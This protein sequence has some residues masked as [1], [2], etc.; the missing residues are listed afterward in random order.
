MIYRL[1]VIMFTD[2]VADP[3][4]ALLYSK[5][6]L[7]EAYR[8]L[9]KK[10]IDSSQIYLVHAFVYFK[11]ASESRYESNRLAMKTNA[12]DNLKIATE[13]GLSQKARSR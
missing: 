6:R 12:F 13:V 10:N 2:R 11:L 5:E 9:E 3:K 4:K 1:A 7:N 8:V